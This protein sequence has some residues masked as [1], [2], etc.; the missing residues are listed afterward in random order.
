MTAAAEDPTTEDPATPS[1]SV[2]VGAARPEEARR[3]LALAAPVARARGAQLLLVYV[4]EPLSQG[5]APVADADADLI[6]GG[7]SVLVKVLRHQTTVDTVLR[8]VA[9][10]YHAGLLILQWRDHPDAGD[11]NA[12]ERAN[13]RRHAERLRRLFLDPPCEAWLVDGSLGGR[14]VRSILLVPADGIPRRETVKA[15]HDLRGGDASVTYL[16]AQ[17]KSNGLPSEALT[18]RL[19][20]G[21]GSGRH[22]VQSVEAKSRERA[23]LDEMDRRA[24]DLL[25]VEAPESSVFPVL[26]APEVPADLLERAEIPM[27][28]VN[29]PQSRAAVTIRRWWDR[30]YRWTESLH[31]AQRDRVYSDLRRAARADRDFRTLTVLSTGIAALGLLLNSAAVIIGAMLVAPFMAPLI[32]LGLAVVYGDPRFMR[33]G[34]TAIAKGTLVAYPIGIL[35]GVLIPHV[36]LGNEVLART[37]PSGLDLLV[38]L[39][40]GAAGA[41]A[42]A[43]RDVSAALPGV[44]IA[45]A[46]VPPLAASAILLGSGQFEE[47]ASAALL[48]ALHVTAISAAVTVVFLWFGFRPE[49]QRLG[50]LRAFFSGF[51]M[52]ATLVIAVTALVVVLG[53]R[54]RA[55]AQVEHAVTTT[56]EEWLPEDAVLDRVEVDA[57]TDE[58]QIRVRVES[59][60]LRTAEDA[61]ALAA[62]IATDL[63]RSVDVDLV[64]IPVARGT[65]GAPTGE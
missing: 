64:V 14:P 13:R 29:Q 20:E 22:S 36:T 59:A 39:L 10:Q 40:S 32:A 65:A 3:L 63:G 35:L 11:G 47:A 30:V 7:L 27:V 51:A 54:D 34:V 19:D 57:S 16:H 52:I 4:P 38:A 12:E 50:R 56:V 46:L 24:Y 15:A 43:R 31:D 44:A 48:Y 61:A 53:N 25:L 60:T 5:A 23:A 21:L 17:A 37:E 6:P 58:L 49:R 33:V 41:Y 62:L 18:R 42:Y 28:V 1:P 45:A 9:R 8:S 55:S 2:V 26:A